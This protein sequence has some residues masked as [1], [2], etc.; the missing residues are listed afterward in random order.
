MHSPW[1]FCPAAYAVLAALAQNSKAAHYAAPALFSERDFVLSAV[2][3]QP[4]SLEFAA[5]AL[6]ADPEAPTARC[7][8]GQ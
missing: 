4:W 6:R 1:A 7:T 5:E 2:A 8:G 3:A